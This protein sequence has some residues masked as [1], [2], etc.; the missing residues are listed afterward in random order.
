MI[1]MIKL[2][3]LNYTPISLYEI[4][5]SD[6]GTDRA[7]CRLKQGVLGIVMGGDSH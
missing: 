5:F 3:C 2:K 1:V 7:L 4:C 6:F